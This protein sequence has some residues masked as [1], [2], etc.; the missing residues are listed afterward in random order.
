MTKR[1]R[2]RIAYVGAGTLLVLAAAWLI[3]WQTLVDQLVRPTATILWLL[4][5]ITLLAVHQQV[6]WYALVL[7][8]VVFVLAW[9]PQGAPAPPADPP[10]LNHVQER[11]RYWRRMFDV[12][13]KLAGH[14]ET[15]QALGDLLA[16]A[17]ATGPGPA[18]RAAAQ[19]A[20]AR[21]E[22]PLPAT[23]HSYLFAPEANTGVPSR[24]RPR[25]RSVERILKFVRHGADAGNEDAAIEECLTCIEAALGFRENYGTSNNGHD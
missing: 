20:L 17:Y 15:R 9:L 24:A 16:S 4:L 21:G 6:Y 10:G 22:I 23:V 3:G 11:V 13:G 8:A 12:E 5:R 1:N 14:S 19:A 7:L 18:A 2:R 25:H